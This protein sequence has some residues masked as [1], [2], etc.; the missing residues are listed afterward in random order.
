[1]ETNLFNQRFELDVIINENTNTLW[2]L[3]QKKRS[4]NPDAMLEQDR[5]LQLAWDHNISLTP[6]PSGWKVS[7]DCELGVVCVNVCPV[8]AVL[9]CFLRMGKVTNE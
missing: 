5:V 2:Q 4:Q 6:I 8:R 3:A 1:M 7:S 9:I